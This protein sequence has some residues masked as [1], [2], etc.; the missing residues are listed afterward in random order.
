MIHSLRKV[1]CVLWKT[2]ASHGVAKGNISTFVPPLFHPCGQ[3]TSFAG[4]RLLS[5]EG[6]CARSAH[7]Q[8]L[9]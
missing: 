9:Y 4:S 1:P 7:V 5:F 8:I 3:N 2:R 6:F